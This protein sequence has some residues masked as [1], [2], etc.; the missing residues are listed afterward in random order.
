MHEKRIDVFNLSQPFNNNLVFFWLA[1]QI[2][3]K[4]QTNKKHEL[5]QICSFLIMGST[6]SNKLNSMYKNLLTKFA[7]QFYVLT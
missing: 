5:I 2:I 7:F 6:F 3:L 4:H 1:L